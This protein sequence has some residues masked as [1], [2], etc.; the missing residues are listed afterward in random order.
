MDV[1][2]VLL[3]FM[4]NSVLLDVLYLYV[5]VIVLRSCGLSGMAV[6]LRDLIISWNLGLTAL[7]IS[8][9]Q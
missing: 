5:R 3:P 7:S 2:A 1:V 6:T 9:I 8:V 4:T